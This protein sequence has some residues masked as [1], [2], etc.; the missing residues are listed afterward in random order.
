[1]ETI[2]AIAF[3]ASF[4]PLRKSNTSATPTKPIRNGSESA[5]ASIVSTPTGSNVLDDDTVHHVGN[6]VETIHHLFEVVID[7]VANDKT[8]RVRR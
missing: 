2:V 6:V 1:M 7:F 5:T 8:H 4:I 3:A